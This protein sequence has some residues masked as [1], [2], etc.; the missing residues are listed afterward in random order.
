MKKIILT[1][2]QKI[3]MLTIIKE[4]NP[5]VRINGQHRRVYLCRCDCGTEKKILLQSLNNGRTFSCGCHQKKVVSN[6]AFAKTHGL[7]SHP[8]FTVWK[9]MIDRCYNNK[10]KGYEYYGGREIII[11]EE[12]LTSPSVFVNWGLDNGWE[13]GLQI[14]RKDN[15]GN[16]EPNNCRFVTRAVNLANRRPYKKRN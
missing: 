15:N 13:K 10:H 8:L 1:P 9:R 3:N 11:C 12:W 2:N 7:S 5:V 4:V 6:G 16:Y 14:D